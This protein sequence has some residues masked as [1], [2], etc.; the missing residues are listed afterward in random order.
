MPGSAVNVCPATAEPLNDGNT[1]FC[2]ATGAAPTTP[3][4]ALAADAEPAEFEAVT[5]T[6]TVPPTSAPTSRYEAE[7]ADVMSAQ[8][9]P[10]ESQRCHWYVN[11]GAGDPLQLP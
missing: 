11:V 2:G 8:P 3:E 7:V 9:C 5:T 6:R 4:T 1:V 10:D